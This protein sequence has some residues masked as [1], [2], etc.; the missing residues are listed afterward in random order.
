MAE[1]KSPHQELLEAIHEY[2]EAAMENLVRCRA[3]GRAIGTG[4]HDYLQAE[5]KCVSLVPAKGP[6]DP[7]KDYG[8]AAFSFSA[9]PVI[10]LEPI[11]VGI[12]LTVP[13]KEDSGRLWLRIPLKMSVS[14]GVFDI[15]VGHQPLI[16]V[17]L[18]F[19]GEL[20]EIYAALH[21]ELLSIFRKELAVFNDSRYAD[22]IGFVP[23]GS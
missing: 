14:G 7:R 11:T 19:E 15:F 13:H 5:E 12:C 9:T 6:F 20:G 1:D 16:R 18:E 2:G 23:S 4:F 10:R 17:P 8:D 21:E 22:G 3:L